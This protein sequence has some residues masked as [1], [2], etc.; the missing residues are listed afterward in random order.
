MPCCG[1]FVQTKTFWEITAI[2]CGKTKGL[3][4]TN[5]GRP[6]TKMTGYFGV[7]SEEYEKK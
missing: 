2:F 5:K 6:F 7:F 4:K 1:I 3:Q